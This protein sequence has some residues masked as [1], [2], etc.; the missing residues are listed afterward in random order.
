[1]KEYETSDDF[2]NALLDHFIAE[3]RRG[4]I[5]RWG[6]EPGE[7]LSVQIQYENGIAC[8]ILDK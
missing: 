8:I 3:S 4:F 1:M 5:E 7:A 6:Q 2:D